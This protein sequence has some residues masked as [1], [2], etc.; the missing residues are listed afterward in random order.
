MAINQPDY[1]KDRHLPV[2]S[3]DPKDRKVLERLKWYGLFL[4]IN[5]FFWWV[6]LIIGIWL[7]AVGGSYLRNAPNY[8]PYRSELGV[9]IFF[10]CMFVI[11]FCLAIIMHYQ[12]TKDAQVLKKYDDN[13]DNAIMVKFFWLAKEQPTKCT[14]NMI[15]FGFIMDINVFA[16]AREILKRPHLTAEQEHQWAIEWVKKYA[17]QHHVTLHQV[18][19]E[20]IDPWSDDPS[21]DPK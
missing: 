14:W 21:K 19:D 3:V 12:V 8:E 16:D 7:T 5:S 2:F 10:L 15:A 17:Y 20:D 11:C 18:E 9:G 6:F 1:F 4:S 13:F